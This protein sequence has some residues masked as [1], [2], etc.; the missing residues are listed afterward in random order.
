MRLNLNKKAVVGVVVLAAGALGG[1]AY[2]ATTDNGASSRQAFLNDA[3]SRAGISPQRLKDALAGALQDR[4][5]AEVKAGRLTQAQANKIVQRFDQGDGLGPPPL[6]GGAHV[7][8]FRAPGGGPLGSAASYLGLSV[9]QLLDQ[10]RGGKSL[11]QVASA[12]HKSTSGLENALVSAERTRLDK[13]RTAGMITA[14]QEQQELGELQSRVKALVNH[15][16]GFHQFR[17]RRPG[18]PNPS[19]SLQAPAPPE[20]VPGPP[21]GAGGPPGPPLPY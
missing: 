2:A 14:Q 3:A 4:L 13:E 15:S 7:Q 12:Q 19:G 8:R 16:G 11:A 17:G 5:N 6:G 21:P 20:G 1:G 9:P 10:L 18:P